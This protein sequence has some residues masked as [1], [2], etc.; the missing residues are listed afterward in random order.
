VIEGSL[1]ILGY[2]ICDSLGRIVVYF[3]LCQGGHSAILYLNHILVEID[4]KQSH[5][6][7]TVS[8]TLSN[9][10]WHLFQAHLTSR[11]YDLNAIVVHSV[12]FEI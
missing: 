10:A 1:G 2:E 3:V 6:I 4:V 12:Q 8:L 9:C 11:P 5:V 7:S